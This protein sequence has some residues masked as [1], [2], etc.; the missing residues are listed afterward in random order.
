MKLRLKSSRSLAS[1][2]F[3][4]VAAFGIIAIGSIQSHPTAKA[5]SA[6]DFKPGKVIDDSIFYNKNTMTVQQIQSFLDRQI[7]ACDT[8]GTGTS[9]YGGGTRAQYAASVGWPAPPYVCIN[10]YYENPTTGETSF[11]KGGGAFSGGISAAQIIYDAAQAYSINPQVLLVILKKESAGPLTYDKWPLKSQYRYA[12][13]Y[14]CPDSGINY[15]AACVSSKSGF[16]KQMTLA[17]WQLNYYKEHPNDYRYGIGLNTIQYAPDPACG[18]KQVNIENIATL[19]LYLYTP[20]TPN[21]GSLNNY[22]GQAPCGSYGNRNFFMF[23]N[24]WFGSTQV[25]LKFSPISTPRWMQTK[26]DVYKTDLVSLADAGALIPKGTQIKFIDKIAVNGKWYLRTEFNYND[27]GYYAIAQDQIE[28]ISYQPITPK[29]VTFTV[30]GYRSHPA[31]RTAV[32]GDSLMR[33]TSVK[34]VDQIIVDGSTYYRTEYNST[35]GQDFGI[36]SRFVSDFA[37]VPLDGPRTFCSNISIN[38]VNPQTGAV[39]DTSTGGVASISITKKTLVNSIWYFQ[40][41]ADDNTTKF[42]RSADLRDVCYASFQG[43]RNMIIKQDA[44]RFNPYTKQTLDTLKK[45]SVIAFSTKILLNGQWY[46]RTMH[47][48]I[49]NIDAVVSAAYVSDY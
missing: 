24:E 9:E 46:F 43:P 13:G 5:V 41:A 18:T 47:N 11:E 39:V 21:V 40:A 36:H 1:L 4:G 2:I 7:G 20:Y 49:N 45:G 17:A 31:P 15:S 8:W 23:F 30:D 25:V 44:I 3:L 37:P 29:W 35:N 32:S 33:G 16:Y 27:G 38:R 48:S 26:N 14:A 28:D 22:P 34:V 19:S 6:L 10:T 42:Y 12:M